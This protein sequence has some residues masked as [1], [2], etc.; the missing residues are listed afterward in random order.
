MIVLFYNL[1]YLFMLAS[2]PNVLNKES[3][4]LTT[5][6]QTQLAVPVWKALEAL[7]LCCDSLTYVNS[8]MQ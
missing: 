7:V 1:L 6:A 8:V 3:Y 2:D 5:F 4:F